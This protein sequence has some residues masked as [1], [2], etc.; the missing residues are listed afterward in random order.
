MNQAPTSATPAV[1][2]DADRRRFYA[3]VDGHL[4]QLVYDLA[5]GALIIRH[6]GVPEPIGG[7]G[8]AGALMA[9]VV[10]FARGQGLSIV[11][12]CSYA[13]AWL[14]RHPGLAGP[15]QGEGAAQ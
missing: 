6:T 15:G 13:S 8:I 9:H 5:P 14:A 1:R 3:Q 11:P 4:A 7:R 12:A 2:H 10:D